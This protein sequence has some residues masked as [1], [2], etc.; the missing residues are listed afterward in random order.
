MNTE[1]LSINYTKSFIQQNCKSKQN[2]M[3]KLF[4]LDF[5]FNILFNIYW[6]INREKNANLWSENVSAVLLGHSISYKK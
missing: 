2:L 5:S 4:N 1:H 6:N 3:H